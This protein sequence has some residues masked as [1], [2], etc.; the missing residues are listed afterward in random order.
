MKS[1]LEDYPKIL[2]K[3]GLFIVLFNG[4]DSFLD[5]Q[6]YSIVSQ[7]DPRTKPI[8]DNLISQNFFKKL[9]VLENVLG[10]ELHEKIKDL[11]DFRNFIAHGMYGVNGLEQISIS[12]QKRYSGKYENISLSEEIIE[13]HIEEERSAMNGLYKL[14][15]ERMNISQEEKDKILA[16]L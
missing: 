10:E 6:F 12:K 7:T 14:N 3:I 4:I 15:L 9:E 16:G 1:P 11:N 2:E 5:T 8:I 13:K